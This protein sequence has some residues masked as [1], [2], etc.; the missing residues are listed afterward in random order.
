[1]TGVRFIRIDITNLNAELAPRDG[2]IVSARGRFAILGSAR[3]HPGTATLRALTCPRK[4][5]DLMKLRY[6]VTLAVGTAAGALALAGVASAAPL[7]PSAA[8]HL[9]APQAEA[10]QPAVVSK[11]EVDHLQPQQVRWGHHWHHHWHGGW[12]RHHWH[13]RHWR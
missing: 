1:M 8:Q 3:V 6:L 7:A 12:H 10:V 2:I 11:A 5:R 4:E 13:H 9:A